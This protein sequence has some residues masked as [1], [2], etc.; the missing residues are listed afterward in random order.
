MWKEATMEGIF[1]KELRKIT[2]KPQS[3]QPAG[4]KEVLC[5]I[6][7]GSLMEEL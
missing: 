7:L 6:R 1:M 3:H 4:L 5:S 2:D